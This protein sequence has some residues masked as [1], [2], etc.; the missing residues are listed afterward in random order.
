[1]TKQCFRGSLVLGPDL[2]FR[3]NALLPQLLGE[4]AVD[5]SEISPSLETFCGLQWTSS[6]KVRPPP[7]G[8]LGPMTE[9]PALI[10][11]NS[12]GPSQFPRASL[13]LAEISV[14]FLIPLEVYLL[15][16]LPI[17]PFVHDSWSQSQFPGNPT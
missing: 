5:G 8:G 1:M 14:V 16:S 15:R 11:E 6:P 9:P 17:E 12:E 2:L 10:W 4:R 7:G 13:G 3:T